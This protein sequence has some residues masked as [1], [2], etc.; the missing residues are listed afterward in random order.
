MTF[1]HN[2]FVIGLISNN[3]IT[4]SYVFDIYLIKPFVLNYLNNMKIC[5]LISSHLH[6]YT[7]AHVMDS[8]LYKQYINL[9]F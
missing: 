5:T 6:E 8:I 1:Y 9:E 7:A 3:G 4:P 2:Q